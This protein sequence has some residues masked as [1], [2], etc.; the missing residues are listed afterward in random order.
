MYCTTLVRAFSVVIDTHDEMSAARL[1][2]LFVGFGDDSNLIDKE[3]FNFEIQEI[4]LIQNDV[5]ETRL[6]EETN[7]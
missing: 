4:E 1:S 2:E 3:N 5:I 6:L 7:S